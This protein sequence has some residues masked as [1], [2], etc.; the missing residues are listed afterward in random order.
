VARRLLARGTAGS[1]GEPAAALQRPDSC[2]ACA[3]EAESL[4]RKARFFLELLDTSSGR[5]RYERSAGVCRPHLLAVV[6]EAGRRDDVARYLLEDWGR[7]LA[8][9]RHRLAEYDRKR[10]HR[11]AAERTADDER[12][13]TDVI[14]LYVGQGPEARRF[15][16]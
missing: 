2:F 16:P 15:L 7:R 10:D 14:G 5:A 6:A 13:W 4:P 11:F 9:V 1:G 12:S 3:E 8:G